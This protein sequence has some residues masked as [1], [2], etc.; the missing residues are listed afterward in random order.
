MELLGKWAKEMAKGILAFVCCIVGFLGYYPVLPAF[1]AV[2]CMEGKIPLAVIIGALGGMICFMTL[3][4]AIKYF[5]ILVVI[6]IAVR[7]FI[8]MNRSCDSISAG[9][10]A[11]AATIA[12][13]CAST[14]TWQE[15]ES[16][17]LIGV[18]EGVMVFGI[19]VGIHGILGLPFHLD[20]FLKKTEGM[21]AEK[22]IPFR[23]M[24]LQRAESLAYAVSGLS[25]VFF[26]LSYPKSSLGK[27]KETV[28][29]E[30]ELENLSE[31]LCENCDNR[32]VCWKENHAQDI[33]M[34]WNNRLMENRYVIAQQLDAMADLMQEWAKVRLNMD[35]HY[36]T[37]L[38][39][40]IYGAKEKGLIVD[41]LHIYEE[42]RRI[43]LEGYIS[44]RWNGGI[45]VKHYLHAA[46]RAFGKAM[47]TGKETKG[48]LNGEPVFI[49]LYEDTKFYG[50]QGVATE[51]KSD[52]RE[53]GDNF[54][55]FSMDDGNY[56][57]CLSDGM[58]S[59]TKAREESEMVVDLLQKFVEAG[60][61]KETAIKLMNLAMVLQ[62]EEDSFS[63][64]DY[65]VIDMYT[66]ETDL[67]KIG[68]AATFI[69]HGE[70][71]ECIDTG[72][73]PAGAD[74]R[75][76]VEI[77]KRKLTNGDFLVMVTDGVIEYLHVRNPK[78]TMIDLIAMTKTE[79]A[80]AM[81]EELM[82]QVMVRCGGFAKDDMT[83]LVTGIWEK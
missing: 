72:T 45:P 82:E 67:I 51:K 18:C 52:S 19:C 65:A 73:L 4:A 13:N 50:L 60:F 40:L 9:I 63:T 62:G 46:E 56:H 74:A 81:A 24:P 21:G 10:I 49:T 1:F 53:N 79:N 58:G 14:A 35:N 76:E 25:D 33:K 11:G 31:G 41:E 26:A 20:Y 22:R 29:Q 61:R 57:I 37:Q 83:I 68:G 71:V 36:T 59:G 43:C 54:A 23:G 77:M 32:E 75:M 12:M 44:T 38:A 70:E 64:L 48:I 55:F 17:L 34:A 47:R 7:M 3:D 69:K 80:G 2:C 5:F 16:L 8:W 30:K 78:E 66:G 27:E 15:N 39:S 6:A 42:K 28:S